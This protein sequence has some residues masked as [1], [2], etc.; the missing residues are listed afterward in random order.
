M[1]V[2]VA[3]VAMAARCA[4]GKRRHPAK[5]VAPLPG[6]GASHARSAIEDAA[7]RNVGVIDDALTGPDVAEELARLANRAAKRREP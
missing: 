1:A 2:V 3:I 5:A 6:P 7:Q 4:S